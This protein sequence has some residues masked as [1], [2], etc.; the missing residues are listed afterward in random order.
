MQLSL[1]RYSKHLG[2][3]L[4]LT[5]GL[6]LKVSVPPLPLVHL[7]CIPSK[8]FFLS[9]VLGV[10]WASPQFKCALSVALT[11]ALLVFF[12]SRLQPPCG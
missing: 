5:K 10:R 7:E 9:L 11:I 12:V 4:V 6:A 2:L 8:T 1:P 3:W